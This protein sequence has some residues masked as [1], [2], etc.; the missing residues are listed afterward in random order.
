MNENVFILIWAVCGVGIYI[1]AKKRNLKAASS[2][3]ILGVLLGIFGVVGYLLM[4]VKP[5]KRNI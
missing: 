4:I 3:A 2:W 5:N 1:D